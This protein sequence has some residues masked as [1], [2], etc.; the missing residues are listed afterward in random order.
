MSERSPRELKPTP[1]TQGTQSLRDG[2]LCAL[3]APAVQFWLFS[4]ERA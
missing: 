3:C 4:G 1:E 2:F